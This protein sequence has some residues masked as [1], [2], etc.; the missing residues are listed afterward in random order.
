MVRRFWINSQ[1]YD[2]WQLCYV[3]KNQQRKQEKTRK[4]ALNIDDS[5]GEDMGE[6]EDDDNIFYNNFVLVAWIKINK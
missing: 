1:M 3:I 2:C 6:E 5:E 4:R